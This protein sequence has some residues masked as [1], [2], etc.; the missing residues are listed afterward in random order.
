MPAAIEIPATLA[1]ARGAYTATAPFGEHDDAAQLILGNS[2][3]LGLGTLSLV[4]DTQLDANSNVSLN[5]NIALS[6]H[7]LTL[8]GTHATTLVGSIS[9]SGALV[10][11]SAVVTTKTTG[12]TPDRRRLD[13]QR[14]ISLARSEL[15]MYSGW[16]NN[17]RL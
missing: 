16:A 9:G 5:N 14:A 12:D 11:L 13:R 17:A 10:P 6:T 2:H 7:T 4:G 1:H 3:A 8:P 15:R